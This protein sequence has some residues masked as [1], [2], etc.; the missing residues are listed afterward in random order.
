MSHQ[1][2]PLRHQRNLRTPRKE[3]SEK[4]SVSLNLPINT[5]ILNNW[6]KHDEATASYVDLRAE[7]EGFAVEADNNRNNYDIIINSVMESV[8]QVN[9]ARIKERTT[10]LKALNM[11]SETLEADSALKATMQKMADTNTTTS[12]NISNLTELLSDAKLPE[13]IP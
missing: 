13:I 10:F 7:V 3:E 12:N 6:V 5:L 1:S 4:L 2:P 11:V 8:E 9:G